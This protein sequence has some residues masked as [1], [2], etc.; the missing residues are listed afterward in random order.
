MALFAGVFCLSLL[1]PRFWCRYVC[2]SG[3][4]LSLSRMKTKD[5]YTF[6][7]SVSVGALLIAFCRDLGTGADA[8]FSAVPA[9]ANTVSL[10]TSR[11]PDVTLP[12][13]GSSYQFG[14]LVGITVDAGE[15]VFV[16]DGP[17]N[18]IRR[19][20]PAGVVTT[21]AGGSAVVKMKPGA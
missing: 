1:G 11:P 16:A 18:T 12:F 13:F 9:S 19:V 2:P 21:F 14:G 8:Q 4:L 20:T 17:N 10:Y 5:D 3:A 6:L 15:N 7:H